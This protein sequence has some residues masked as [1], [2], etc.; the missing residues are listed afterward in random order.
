MDFGLFKLGPAAVL[1]LGP[2]ADAA[3]RARSGR[4]ARAL[5]GRRAADPDRFPAVDAPGTI[6]TDDPGQTAVDHRGHP[7]DRERGLGDVRAQNDLAAIARPQCAI[8]FFGRQVSRATA[9]RRHQSGRPPA[10]AVW[11]RRRISANPGRKTSTWPDLLTRRQL[12]PRSAGAISS[13]SAGRLTGRYCTDTGCSPS[14][15]ADDRA[16]IQII[17]DR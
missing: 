8:L 16:A 3:S 6:V 1:A 2:E 4:P 5:V 17:R 14:V 11:P 10:R 7:V 12:V 15:D 9:A 13:A